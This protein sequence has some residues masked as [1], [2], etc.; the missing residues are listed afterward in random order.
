MIL[1]NGIKLVNDLYLIRL[2]RLCTGASDTKWS[3]S[4][5]QESS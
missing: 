3:T 4:T 1:L 5:L 2:D